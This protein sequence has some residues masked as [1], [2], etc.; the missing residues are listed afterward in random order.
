MEKGRES[1]VKEGDEE[2][3]DKHENGKVIWKSRGS[4]LNPF[5]GL[6]HCSSKCATPYEDLLPFCPLSVHTVLKVEEE[7]WAEGTTSPLSYTS[8]QKH[9]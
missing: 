4:L 1:K 2:D 6:P 7:G 8:I 5:P 3:E 9:V